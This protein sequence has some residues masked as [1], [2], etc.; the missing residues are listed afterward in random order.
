MSRIAS[1][2]FD[3]QADA[4]N[5]ASDLR[6]LGVRDSE[7]SILMRQ[8][9]AREAD[10]DA[11]AAEDR[12]RAARAIVGGGAARAGRGVMTLSLAGL[13]PLVAAGAIAAAAIPGEGTRGAAGTLA[14]LLAPHGVTC[15]EATYHERHLGR[16][17]VLLWVGDGAPV[18][19]E[20]ITDTLYRNGGHDLRRPGNALLE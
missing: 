16:G 9:G 11:N 19:I 15:E 14:E 18:A 4:Q 17:G 7:V 1:A 8:G 12:A 2:I 6:G 5:A 20:T 3:T 10:A 13:G